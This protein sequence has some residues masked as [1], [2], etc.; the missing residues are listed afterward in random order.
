MRHRNQ[1]KLLGQVV[2]GDTGILEIQGWAPSESVLMIPGNHN[3]HLSSLHVSQLPPCKYSPSSKQRQCSMDFL[4]HLLSLGAAMDLQAQEHTS[5]FTHQHPLGSCGEREAL[6]TTRISGCLI[7]EKNFVP[8][9]RGGR[10]DE[11]I[12]NPLGKAWASWEVNARD[13]WL[14]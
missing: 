13:I 11:K 4:S 6:L 8:V 2:V 1:C 14:S 12:P 10:W 5:T 9:R 3:S 7:Y